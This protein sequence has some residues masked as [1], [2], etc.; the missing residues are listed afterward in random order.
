MHKYGEQKGEGVFWDTDRC[1]RK[2]FYW[3]LLI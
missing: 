2:I 3:P 1:W